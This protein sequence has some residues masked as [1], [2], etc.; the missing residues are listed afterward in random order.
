MVNFKA[1]QDKWQ[2]KWAKEKIFETEINKKKKKFFIT[3]PYPYISGSLHIGHARVVTEADV[4]SRY[5]RMKGLNVLYPIAFHISGT[6]VLGI[7]MAIKNKDKK[8][9]EIYKSYVRPYVKDKKEVEKVV[10]SFK[11]PKKLVKFFI[12]KMIDEFATLG[13]AVDWRRSFTSG[14]MMHQKLVEWQFGKYKAKDYLIQG[15]YPVLYSKTLGNAVG[16]DDI[17]DGDTDPVD[18]LEFTLLKF[19]YEDAFLVAATLRP[20]TMYGQTNMWIH[21]DVEYVKA[22]VDNEIWIISRECAEKLKF[23]DKNIKVVGKLLGKS[24][25]GKFCVAPVINREIIIL[26]SLHCDPNVGTGLVTSVPSDAPFDWIA[27][28]E[29]QESDRLCGKYGLDCSVIKKLKLIPIIKSK[30]YGDFPAVEITKRMG[31]TSL[32]Q[33]EKLQKATQEIY[34]LGFH[35]GVMMETCGKYAGMKV[36]VAKEE[37]KND[38]LKAKKAD[39]MYDASRVAKSRD[40]GEVIVAI[41]DNQWF[42]DFNA[43]GWKKDAHDCLSKMDIVP[44]K[45]RK[46][47][48]DTF[49]WLDK[50][51]C[52]RK[53]GLGTKL[54]YD[55]EW[56]IESLSDSTLYMT[57]YTL[58]D[59]I[60][61]FK[62]K[63][64][65]LNPE[66]FDYVYLGRGKL[67]DVAKKLGMPEKQLA[68]MKDGFD[69][70][71]PND[72]RHTFT[73]H[74]SNHLSFMIFA[75]AACLQKK[76]WPKKISFHGMVLSGGAKMS[77]SKGNV[78]TLMDVNNLFGADTFRAF[79]CN[80]T[81]V[82]STLNWETSEVERMKNHLL[83]LFALCQEIFGNRKSGKLNDR[84]AAF[85]SKF[86]SSVKQAGKCLDKMDLRDYA[87][88]VLHAIPRMYRKAKAVANDELPV[89]NDYIADRYVKMLAPLLP[90]YAEEIWSMANKDFVSLAAWP[91]YDKSKIN[92]VAEFKEELMENLSTDIKHILKLVK[93]EKPKKI[94][95]F[96]AEGWKY[97]FFA[98]FKELVEKTHD[99]KAILNSIM[100]TDMKKHGQEIIKMIP[101]LLKDVSKV[102]RMIL[103]Q[104]TEYDLL[105]Q[106]KDILEKEFGAKVEVIKADESKEAKARQAA[107]GKPAILVE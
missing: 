35:T 94:T 54:P 39:V 15:K 23:Q 80:S 78:V 50:R 60:K 28:K 90:H 41:L 53:R 88:I 48:E 74:L 36:V 8:K 40:G 76:N 100:K 1:I 99:M 37:M 89:L 105:R 19:K 46:Q 103:D 47:F 79:L 43:K 10:A 5:L 27:L 32:G 29:L 75:H 95:L 44:E 17:I 91:K 52:A 71:Y 21:P 106:N 45:F 102:P 18:K 22:K 33:H 20:E 58:A 86:E 98:M 30:G 69:Y 13:L 38:L 66:F 3:I 11:D 83:S 87:N 93:V 51:P 42:I 64:K 25:L 61:K 67:K 68:E 104:G 4:Y 12:P 81:S 7:S 107:P 26:P 96:V 84:F 55:K 101:A 73:A 77:K 85:V 6:P 65:Q 59:K 56:V 34:K 97:N 62:I 57:L 49:S 92:P 9:I 16:E 63:E 82:D 24:L 70:W 2:K 72:H 14:D 31:I